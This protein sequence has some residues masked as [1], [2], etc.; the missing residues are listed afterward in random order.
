MCTFLQPKDSPSYNLV[1]Q[2]KEGNIFNSLLL[3]VWEGHVA[4]VQQRE[5]QMAEPDL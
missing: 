5:V 1:P 3:E 4:I 2:K